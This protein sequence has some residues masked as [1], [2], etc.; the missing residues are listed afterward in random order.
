MA[1]YKKWWYSSPEN[2]LVHQIVSKGIPWLNTA[3]WKL[4]LWQRLI[5][6][7]YRIMIFDK[8]FTV[9]LSYYF[10][11]LLLTFINCYL[12]QNNIHI[13]VLLCI[14]VLSL[15]FTFSRSLRTVF[16][17]V[18]THILLYRFLENPTSHYKKL[19]VC[20]SKCTPWTK[21]VS[22]F[23]GNISSNLHPI[24]KVKSV[25]KSA[26]SEDFKNVLSFEILPS[27]SLDNWA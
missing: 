10:S 22:I 21:K 20:M 17:H 27:R 5:S 3:D 18:Q 4:N 24:Q 8:N 7:P 6:H 14:L 15:L 19:S 9:Q 11:I 25:F 12:F 1:Q 26:C 16:G 2:H 23:L 13:N